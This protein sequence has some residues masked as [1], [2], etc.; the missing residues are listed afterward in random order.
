M[1]RVNV[2]LQKKERKKFFL[3]PQLDWFVAGVVEAV[4]AE[5][6]GHNCTLEPCR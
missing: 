2:G 3:V 4:A 1:K 5:T 6:V